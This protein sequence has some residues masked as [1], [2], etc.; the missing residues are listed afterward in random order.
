MNTIGLMV[1]PFVPASSAREDGR[2][3]EMWEWGLY[4][5]PD[6]KPFC[7]GRVTGG[8]ADAVVAGDAAARGLAG[9]ARPRW[10]R[11]NTWCLVE[12]EVNA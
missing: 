1:S 9:Y 5:G 2:T 3:H 8:F 10:F 4:R 12:Y 11:R 6:E 7:Y